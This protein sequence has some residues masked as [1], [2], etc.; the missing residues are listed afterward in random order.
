MNTRS[1]IHLDPAQENN[2]GSYIDLTATSECDSVDNLPTVTSFSVYNLIMATVYKDDM[3]EE[4]EMS[5]RPL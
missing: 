2:S 4:K 5:I 3:K 1:P